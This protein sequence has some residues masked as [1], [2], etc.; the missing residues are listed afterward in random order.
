MDVE[1][2]RSHPR[3][4]N[5]TGAA[6]PMRSTGSHQVPS[7]LRLFYACRIRKQHS[8]RSSNLFSGVFSGESLSLRTRDMHLTLRMAHIQRSTPKALPRDKR[9]SCVDLTLV[10][11]LTSVCLIASFYLV[12]R[13]LWHRLPGISSF[14]RLRRLRCQW[15]HYGS[16]PTG[17][18]TQ[19]CGVG[20]E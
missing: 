2:Q 7:G 15:A 8:S 13:G 19:V 16:F 9:A 5:A 14:D 3:K 12:D 18:N 10:C 11:F 6:S 17:W 20:S 1:A 4:L